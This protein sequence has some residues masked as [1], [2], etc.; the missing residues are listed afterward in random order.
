MH[1]HLSA[2]CPWGTLQ[3][4]KKNY[5]ISPLG[6][7]SFGKSPKGQW[8]PI[9]INPLS[10]SARI[11]LEPGVFVFLFFLGFLV[12][13]RTSNLDSLGNF[14]SGCDDHISFSNRRS[15]VFEF[16]FQTHNFRSLTLS[17]HDLLRCLFVSSLL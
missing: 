15:N 17:V 7:I 11:D 14:V 6:I 5:F 12:F 13:V 1:S 8:Q 2:S 10:F 9:G 16:I 4:Y 3:R